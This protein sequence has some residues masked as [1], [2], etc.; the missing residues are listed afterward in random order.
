MSEENMK[1]L[2]NAK[3]WG[4]GNVL[5][6]IAAV[7]GYKVE[8]VVPL[9]SPNRTHVVVTP[10]GDQ[11]HL[12]IDPKNPEVVG[13]SNIINQDQLDGPVPF[14]DD[15]LVKLANAASAL[16]ADRKA[17][18]QDAEDIVRVTV[19]VSDHDLETLG[20]AASHSK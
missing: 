16:N 13:T 9:Q 17:Q 11:I 14:Q 6:A 4:S 12:V 7:P 5:E 8:P 18:D 2:R 19:T 3:I 1:F 10:S 15:E 20:K